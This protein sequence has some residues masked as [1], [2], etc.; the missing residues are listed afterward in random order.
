MWQTSQ[1]FYKLISYSII[2]SKVCPWWS[3]IGELVS[4]WGEGFQALLQSS[5]KSKFKPNSFEPILHWIGDLSFSRMFNQ[6]RLSWLQL[7]SHDGLAFHRINLPGV[8][9]FSWRWRFATFSGFT[10]FEGPWAIWKSTPGTVTLQWATWVQSEIWNSESLFCSWFGYSV[11]QKTAPPRSMMSGPN[12]CKIT[13]FGLLLQSSQEELEPLVSSH[14]VDRTITF[15]GLAKDQSSSC[16]PTRKLALDNVFVLKCFQRLW[17]IPW[18]ESLHLLP[19]IVLLFGDESCLSFS[20]R[21][22]PVPGKRL[23]KESQN[24]IVESRWW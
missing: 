9:S 14:L 23:W 11:W 20:F 3:K 4:S 13:I 15:F 7:C 21:V 1:S 5:V 10:N 8:P 22:S 17:F 19:S 24:S 2:K 18:L 12:E 6:T 16:T